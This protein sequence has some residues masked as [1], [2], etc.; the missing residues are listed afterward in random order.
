MVPTT[1]DSPSRPFCSAARDLGECASGRRCD[2]PASQSSIGEL[3]DDGCDLGPSCEPDELRV[4]SSRGHLH[5]RRHW[6]RDGAASSLPMGTGRCQGGLLDALGPRRGVGRL[7]MH[8]RCRAPWGLIDSASPGLAYWGAALLRVS[9]PIPPAC[10]LGRCRRADDVPRRL[11][12]RWPQSME[13]TVGDGASAW[14]PHASPRRH[15]LEARRAGRSTDIDA[16]GS[17]AAT[18]RRAPRPLKGRRTEARVVDFRRADQGVVDAMPLV[19]AARAA[20][21]P[22]C[23]AASSPRAGYPHQMNWRAVHEKP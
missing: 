14:R 21:C 10:L 4:P 6:V 3:H 7:G 9:M 15:P 18:P 1:P 20:R 2:V 17:L 16:G 13:S 23:G 11:F 22:A 8:G 19:D 12:V 5:P